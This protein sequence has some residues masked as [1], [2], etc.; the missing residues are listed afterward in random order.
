LGRW[1]GVS[2][3]T[4]QN[5]TADEI[6]LA[7]IQG[8]THGD[9][10]AAARQQYGL[11]YNPIL[12]AAVQKNANLAWARRSQFSKSWWQATKLTAANVYYGMAGSLAAVIDPDLG[13]VVTAASKAMT[14]HLSSERRKIFDAE[15]LR[16][17]EDMKKRRATETNKY[18]YG[19][20]GALNHMMAHEGR[21]HLAAVE[22][23]RLARWHS[24]GL[25]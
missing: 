17:I 12:S 21:R 18:N 4:F 9:R 20:Q 8:R 7:E 1:L 25:T 14:L 24:W 6:A 13:D 16:D 22:A 10:V 23:D 19:E 11:S 5:G 2:A 3:A 15:V